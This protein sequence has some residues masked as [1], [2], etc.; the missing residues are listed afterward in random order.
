MLGM[1]YSLYLFII[2]G[3]EIEAMFVDNL[4]DPDDLILGVTDGHTEQAVCAV[5]HDAVH[6]ILV[7]R[8]LHPPTITQMDIKRTNNA[9]FI[10]IV[11]L[12][13]EN[14]VHEGLLG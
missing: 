2:F 11:A 14:L 3:E 8:V 9:T 6:V 10:A 5:A 13:R 7:A 1:I 4:G 12:Y